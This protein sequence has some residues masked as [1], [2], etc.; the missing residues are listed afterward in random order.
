MI[1]HFALKQL[2]VGSDE[3]VF[4]G[5]FGD[6]FNAPQQFVFVQELEEKMWSRGEG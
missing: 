1:T 6:I 4:L 5:R 2:V 3:L